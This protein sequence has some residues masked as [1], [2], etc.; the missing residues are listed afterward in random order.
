MQGRAAA[1]TTGAIDLRRRPPAHVSEQRLL[2]LARGGDRDAFAQ[3]YDR[4]HRDLLAFCRHMLGVREDAEDVVQHAFAQ[5]WSALSQ[6]PELRELRPWLFVIARHR[7]IDV[8]R[9]RSKHPESAFGE[10]ATD[11]LTDVVGRRAELREL[12]GDLGRLPERQR[13]ALLLAELGG[14]SHAQ[15][16]EAIDARADQVKALV[17]QARSTLM[18]ERAARDTTCDE[19]REQLSTLRG[20]S[21]LRGPLRRHLRRCAGCRDFRDN[22]RTQRRD[23]ALLLPVI[24]TAGLR[25]ATL[26][27]S[28]AGAGGAVGAAAVGPVG[29]GALGGGGSAGGI[30]ALAL[31]GAAVKALAGLA[32]LCAVIGVAAGAREL[33]VGRGTHHGRA[34]AHAAPPRAHR[35]AAVAPPAGSTAPASGGI[36]L[37]GRRDPLHGAVQR[38]GA[39]GVTGGAAAPPGA[40]TATP[41]PG[42]ALH[43][44]PLAG[45]NPAR[46]G[47]GVSHSRRHARHAPAATVRHHPPAATRPPGS[48]AGPQPDGPAPPRH[49]GTSTGPGTGT[50]AGNGV[51]VPGVPQATV[52]ARATLPIA[53]RIKLA[54]P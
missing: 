26:H 20:G 12:L 54:G 34:R 47:A 8:L 16:A 41:V 29:A 44:S 25:A 19:I 15:I 3:L 39:A 48:R 5:A 23:L 38:H 18:A 7:C 31:K 10:P 17:Y 37:H 6:R 49:T 35:P 33:T 51:T 36:G 40:N 52:P 2:E 53:A 4:H 1:I 43:G 27:G 46:R 22:L 30:G 11:G 32:G 21:L 42:L 9:A 50:A 45:T 14:L 24:P 13:A 28:F